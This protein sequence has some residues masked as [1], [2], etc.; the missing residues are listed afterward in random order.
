MNDEIDLANAPKPWWASKTIIGAI[1]VIAA[2]GARLAGWEVDTSALT[3]EVLTAVSLLGGALAWWGRVKAERPISR[4][5][6]APGVGNDPDAE[7]VPPAA[8][9]LAHPPAGVRR[10]ERPAQAEQLPPEPGRSGGGSSGRDP[11]PFGY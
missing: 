9:P 4:R 8:R 3:N 5:R 11:G 2:Q 7:G 1:V 6:I 10:T